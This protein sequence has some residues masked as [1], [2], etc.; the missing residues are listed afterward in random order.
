MSNANELKE[1]IESYFKGQAQV[2]MVSP[3]RI[4]VDVSK[5]LDRS[6]WIMC[7]AEVGLTDNS[8]NVPDSF[9]KDDITVVFFFGP[10]QK[11]TQKNQNYSMFNSIGGNKE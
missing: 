11:F 4:E 10:L 9:K 7:A 6:E 8:R 2:Y 1:A 5:E 3:H